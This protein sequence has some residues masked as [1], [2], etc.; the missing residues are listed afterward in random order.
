MNG[1]NKEE[2]KEDR[3]DKE[4]EDKGGRVRKRK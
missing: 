2:E 3:E 4:N 1:W